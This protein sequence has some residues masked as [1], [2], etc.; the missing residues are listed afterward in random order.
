M[1]EPGTP[2]LVTCPMKMPETALYPPIKRYLEARGYQVQAEVKYCDIV[3]TQGNDLI[4]VELKTSANLTLLIQATARQK[5]TASVYVAIPKPK[6]SRKHWLGIQHLLKRLE[7]GLLLVEEGALGLSVTKLFDPA[8]NSTPSGRKNHKKRRAVIQEIAARS[9][10][11]NVAGSSHTK[12]MTAYR[13]TAIYIASCLDHLGATSPKLLRRLGTG[14]KT[15]SILSQNHYGWFQR[16]RRGIY[17]LNDQGRV[18]ARSYAEVYAR[19]QT[20]LAQIMAYR[21]TKESK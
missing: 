6:S 9:A 13:E 18:E 1:G 5:I 10:S 4:V 7:L 15:T 17:L 20:K 3:A 12:L 19:A 16:V 21:M 2:P 14:D 8:P 11:Y